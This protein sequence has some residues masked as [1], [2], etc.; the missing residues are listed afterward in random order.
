[1]TSTLRQIKDD[2]CIVDCEVCWVY[3]MNCQ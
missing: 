2:Q 1:V 3:H